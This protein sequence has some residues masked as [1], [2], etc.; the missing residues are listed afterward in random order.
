[1]TTSAASSHAIAYER[2]GSLPPAGR[3]G[4]SMASL[5]AL[6]IFSLRQHQHGKR[7][8]VMLLLML[9]PPGLAIVVRA[10]APDATSLAIEF[11]F[12]FML[13]P[14]ALLPLTALIYSSGIIQDEQE[15][16]TITYLLMRPIPKWAI[17]LMKLSATLVTTIALVIVLTIVTYAAIY[18]GTTGTPLSDVALRCLKACAV[19]SL[20]IITYCCLF[21]LMSLITKRVLVVGILYIAIFE[22]LFANL[23]L[24]IRLITIIYYARMIAYRGLPFVVTTP[25]GTENIA[26]E[27]WQLDLQNDPDLLTHPSTSTC[28]LTLILAA[29]VCAAAAAFLC[30]RREFHVKTPEK[31]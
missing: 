16:Q 13:I 19:H 15:D 7:W 24:S 26:A 9:I 12:A 17:Y 10:T 4:M 6:F 18:L 1:M 5:W 2:S 30:S 25:F 8:I 23:P 11:V 20:A 3:R 31:A 21:G 29:V 22:G 27:A 14:Q 28:L